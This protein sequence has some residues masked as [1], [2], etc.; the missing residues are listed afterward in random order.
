MAAAVVAAAAAAV[1]VVAVVVG[2]TFIGHPYVMSTSPL[3]VLISINFHLHTHSCIRVTV[4][5]S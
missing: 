5:H 1:M 2:V 4:Q 3:L